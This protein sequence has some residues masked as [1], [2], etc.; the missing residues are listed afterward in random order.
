MPRMR[1]VNTIQPLLNF[2]CFQWMHRL[3]KKKVPPFGTNLIWSSWD[4]EIV[5]NVVIF[6]VSNRWQS[7]NLS[8]VS[9]NFVFRIQ[10]LFAKFKPR[11]LIFA[12]RQ[13][14]KVGCHSTDDNVVG[15]V[16]KFPSTWVLYWRDELDFG[17]SGKFKQLPGCDKTIRDPSIAF[18]HQE[19]AFVT[20]T[21]L[22]GT[23]PCWF[24]LGSVSIWPYSVNEPILLVK[25]VVKGLQFK[26]DGP[27]KL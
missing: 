7:I 20:Y 23:F 17:E 11:G 4:I 21:R 15:N 14:H 1:F 25:I 26:L 5:L 24:H 8:I 18:L 2:V 12:L 3:Q 9:S 6:G 22:G 27:K 16:W 19:N 10:I 13:F